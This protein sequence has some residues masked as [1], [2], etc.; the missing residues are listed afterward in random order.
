MV[1]KNLVA[2]ANDDNDLFA[3]GVGLRQKITKR[4]ALTFEYF[5]SFNQPDEQDLYNA[6]SIGVDIETGGHVFQLHLTNSRAIIENGFITETT[7]DFFDGEIHIGFNISRVFNVGKRA[8][9]QESW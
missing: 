2:T 4:T 6:L 9:S 5:Y 3:L 1:H 7:D 8:N